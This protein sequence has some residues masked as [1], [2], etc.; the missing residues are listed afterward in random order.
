MKGPTMQLT[1]EG[2]QISGSLEKEILG[3][4]NYRYRM[5]KSWLKPTNPPSHP[6]SV[7]VDHN[8]LVYVGVPQ[9]TRGDKGL[10]EP[11]ETPLV[12]IC[13][14]D[15]N[16][17]TSWGTGSVVHSH[18][19]HI[20][21]EMLY[22]CDKDASKALIFTLDGRPLR[23]LGQHNVHADTGAINKGDPVLRQTGPFNFP[24]KLVPSPW[25]ELYVADGYKNARVHR[26][27]SNGD[28]INS[29]GEW[30]RS[31]AN[32]FHVPHS[33][34]ALDNQRV[35]VASRFGDNVQ[36]FDRYGNFLDLW[37][38][39]RTPTDVVEMPDGNI[40]V[41]EHPSDYFAEEIDWNVPFYV[42][43]LDRAGNVLSKIPSG[44]AHSMAVDS[45]GDIYLT[46]HHTVNKLV[47]VR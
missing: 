43:I 29:W 28:L 12:F 20:A 27:E 8:D 10:I 34:L 2:A 14:P 11:L 46:D 39:F 30:G 25:G 17:L 18:G 24:A 38:G 40:A 35:Y 4:G 3:G 45:R 32:K 16:Q 47:R 19:L 37:E 36:V 1:T 33:V 21:N 22:V 31:G 9:E 15:G 41:C 42:T 5:M 44:F 23:I 7:A 13:D 6:L 26:F